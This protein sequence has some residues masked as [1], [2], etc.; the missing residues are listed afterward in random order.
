MGNLGTTPA[1]YAARPRFAV[2]GSDVPDLA[3]DLRGLLVEETTAGLY[4]CEATFAN[5]GPTGGSVDFLYLDRQLFDFGTDLTVRAGSGDTEGLLFE[6]RITGLEAHYPPQRPPEVTILAEDR[7]QD[8]RMTR[9]TRVF[10]DVSDQDVFQTIAAAHSLRP[11]LD[12]D[13]PTYRVLAQVN[14]SDL[15]FLRARARAIDAEVWVEGGTLYARP[16]PQR[17]GDAIALTYLEGLHEFQ[18]LADL[19]E[20]RTSLVVSGW[21][22]AAKEAVTHESDEAAIQSELNGFDS[23]AAVL[24]RAFGMRPERIVHTAPFTLREAQAVAEAEFRAMAR[25]FVTGRGM[26][27]GDA[28]LRVGARVDLRGLGRLFEGRYTVT[29]VQ[30]TFDDAYGYRTHF[31]VERPGL[32]PV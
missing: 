2:A 18:V 13:G 21:D 26:A 30:H 25:R 7:L 1:L 15:A 29:A 20:Q 9:R 27:E 28:R 22:V 6:G 16:R 12:L 17:G 14:Q 31:T 11:E 32:N 10:E 5:W 19:A 4:R 3:D 23:G 8:L 24:D